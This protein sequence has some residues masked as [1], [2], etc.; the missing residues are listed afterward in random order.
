M[1]GS[2]NLFDQKHRWRGVCVQVGGVGGGAAAVGDP[3]RRRHQRRCA[4]ATA[5]Y[6]AV[7]GQAAIGSVAGCG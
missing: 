6:G 3:H 1:V 4:G 5:V 7:P 2:E